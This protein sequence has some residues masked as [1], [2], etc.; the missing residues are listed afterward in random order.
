MILLFAAPPHQ[1][2]LI[3]SASA[4]PRIIDVPR[5]LFGAALVAHLSSQPQPESRWDSVEIRSVKTPNSQHCVTATKLMK[6]SCMFTV[7]ETHPY[8]NSPSLSEADSELKLMSLIK[9][10]VIFTISVWKH[11]RCLRAP[12]IINLCQFEPN[13]VYLSYESI[14]AITVTLLIINLHSLLPAGRQLVSLCSHKHSLGGSC[15]DGVV[16]FPCSEEEEDV[17]RRAGSMPPSAVKMYLCKHWQRED[18]WPESALSA[19]SCLEGRLGL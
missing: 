1:P 14:A 8:E 11:T 9:Y 4:I 13:D 19:S 3:N 6:T 15:D 17:E 7:E 10:F 2:T 12:R 5:P 18:W 16:F